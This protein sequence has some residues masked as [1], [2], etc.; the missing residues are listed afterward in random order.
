MKILFITPFLPSP[1]RFGG[2]RRLDGLMR[3]LAKSHEVSVL[4]FNRTDEWEHS[5]LEA[6]R[7][8]CREVVTIPN[9]D[10]TDTRE[11]RTLQ[12]RS[13]V[14]V[15]SFEHLLA[16]RRADF[17]AKLDQML[18]ATQY[19]VVQVEFAQMAAFHFAAHSRS[20]PIFVLDEH[21]IEFDILRRTARA[22]G[23]LSRHLYNALNWRKLAREERTAWRRFDGVSLTSRRDEELI[24]SEYPSAHTAVVPNGVDV[25]EFSPVEGA[26]ER[27]MLLFFGAI[28]Y[29]PNHDGVVYF[30]DEVF[31]KIRLKHP[32]ARFC[33]LGPGA[34][35]SVLDRQGNGVE[36]LGMVDDVGPYID[37]AAA[38]VVPLRLGGGTRLKI[39]EALSKG[40]PVVSTRLGAEGI[41]VVHDQH[42]LLADDPQEFA[43][44]VSRVLTDA[45]LALRLGK[46]GRELMEQKYSWRSIV[47]GLERFYEARLSAR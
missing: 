47:A 14:S 8:Y 2:Q 16:A 33:I 6:T 34:R 28:N 9:L 45:A 30:I 41:D 12:A 31:P 44:Q 38:V 23:E 20:G 26:A 7:G 39:V 5:S 13:L 22:K 42:L 25:S 29:H 1:P 10:L 17:Q 27:E 21:N 35:Q 11:K 19:D 3:G 43:N 46:A 4:S 40:K 18:R 32:N 37:R 15:H 24:L 36:V